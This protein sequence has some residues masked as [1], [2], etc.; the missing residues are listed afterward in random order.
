MRKNTKHKKTIDY[1]T[2]LMLLLF[3]GSAIFICVIFPLLDIPDVATVTT[4]TVIL[5]SWFSRPF[6]E[7]RLFDAIRLY[8]VLLIALPM[9]S[10][11]LGDL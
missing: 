6:G 8:C 7:G 1:G 9:F 2:G 10:M 4:E 11:A 3:G 5:I